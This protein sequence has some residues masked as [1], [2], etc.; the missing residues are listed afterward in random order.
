MA[1]KVFFYEFMIDLVCLC[2][3]DHILV[4]QMLK[5]HSLCITELVELV[6]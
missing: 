5:H 6:R 3:R 1:K 2:V 4:G